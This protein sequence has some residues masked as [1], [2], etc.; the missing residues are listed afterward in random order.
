MIWTST[1]KGVIEGDRD[2]YATT[3][4]AAVATNGSIIRL[5]VHFTNIRRSRLGFFTDPACTC[6]IFGV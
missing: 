6:V 3:P 1:S 4:L 2:F 5:L